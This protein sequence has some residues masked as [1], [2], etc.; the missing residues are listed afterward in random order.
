MERAGLRVD[1]ASLGRLASVFCGKIGVG[2]GCT[3]CW[4]SSW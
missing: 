1:G 4:L 2:C 3:W